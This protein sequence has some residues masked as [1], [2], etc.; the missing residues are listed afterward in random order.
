MISS[1]A[2]V[3]FTPKTQVM[4]LPESSARVPSGSV[5]SVRSATSGELLLVLEMERC[6]DRADHLEGR[7]VGFVEIV[8][9]KQRD[10]LGRNQHIQRQR[11]GSVLNGIS[12]RNRPHVEDLSTR[13]PRQT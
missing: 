7:K 11:S 12:R 4:W 6:A 13:L 2:L 1:V 8:M 9:T 5:S 3:A 10:D